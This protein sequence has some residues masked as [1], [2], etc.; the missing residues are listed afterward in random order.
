MEEVKEICGVVFVLA[1][2]FM[3]S[4]VAIKMF[5]DERKK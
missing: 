2:W 1:L 4:M 5:W 3:A